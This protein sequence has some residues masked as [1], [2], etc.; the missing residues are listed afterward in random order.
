[1]LAFLLLAVVLIVVM[2]SGDSKSS[3]EVSV[4]WKTANGVEFDDNPVALLIPKGMKEKIDEIAPIYAGE[5]YEK[6]RSNEF[7][8]CGAY[9]AVGV[10]GKAWFENIPHGHYILV[11]FPNS[12]MGTI[13]EGISEDEARRAEQQLQPFFTRVR[14]DFL[15]KKPIL[16][17]DIEVKDHV[18]DVR[19][20]FPKRG[21]QAQPAE[22]GVK[23]AK[24]PSKTPAV[25]NPKDAVVDEARRE[26]ERR[27]EVERVIQDAEPLQAPAIVKGQINNALPFAQQ[28]W[29]LATNEFKLQAAKRKVYRSRFDQ[30]DQAAVLKWFFARNSFV[31]PGKYDFKTGEYTLDPVLWQEY[32]AKG[33]ALGRLIPETTD[34]CVVLMQFKVDA[35]TAE[36]WRAKMEKKAFALTVWYR[37]K[38]V[39]RAERMANPHWTDG[40]LAYDIAFVADVLKFEEA[41][42]ETPAQPQPKVEEAKPAPKKEA[43][44]RSVADGYMKSLVGKGLVSR[45]TF[46]G[47]YK[48]PKGKDAYAVAYKVA[49]VN[50]RKVLGDTVHLYVFKDKQGDWRISAFSQDGV[51]VMLGPPPRGF[52]AVP[53][54][55]KEE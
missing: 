15:R 3:V 4:N 27:K 20:E 21:S 54:P 44:P 46:N 32:Y 25:E 34:S 38:E 47:F 1:M 26:E 13:D 5:G 16:V 51:H 28:M 40:R 39:K 49:S 6:A 35:A 50:G 8:K 36:Q 33:E 45:P 24:R 10:G 19:H 14:L 31:G 23:E 22:G 42:E 17:R 48:N 18:V 53:D 52:Q 7:R 30:K 12:F 43:T 55:G 11:V 2:K 37:L 29:D 41:A 9:L